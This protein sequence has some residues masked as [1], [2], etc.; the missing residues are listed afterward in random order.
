MTQS[1]IERALPHRPPMLLVDEIV[2]K[3]DRSIV[4]LKTFRADEFFVQGH[5]PGFPIVP[6]V[7]LCECAVQSGAILLADK[8]KQGAGVPV[9]T[10]MNDVRFKRMVKPGDTI[11]TTAQID[12]VLSDAYFLSATVRVAGQIAARLS[13]AC[14]IT[15]ET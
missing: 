13:F 5:Y 15:S 8:T 12:E 14:T 4:C 11:E 2:S 9:L 7:I 6:G 1:E 10:R 3:D